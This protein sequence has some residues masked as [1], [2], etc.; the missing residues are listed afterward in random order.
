[1]HSDTVSDIRGFVFDMKGLQWREG[2][3]FVFE[4]LLGIGAKANK[5]AQF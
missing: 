5:S 4:F 2:S 1:M 3:S